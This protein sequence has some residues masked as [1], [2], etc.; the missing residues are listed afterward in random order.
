M[1]PSLHGPDVLIVP[2]LSDGALQCGGG[3]GGGGPDCADVGL[4]AR[5]THLAR[6][7]LPLSQVHR[8]HTACTLG[9]ATEQ[10]PFK[11]ALFP[12]SPV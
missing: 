4:P 11:Q 5:G 3:G 6:P 9:R 1:L 7:G 2:A 8:H 12:V 10:R